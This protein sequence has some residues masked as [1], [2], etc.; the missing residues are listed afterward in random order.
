MEGKKIHCTVRRMQLCLKARETP[1]GGREGGREGGGREGGR[2][3]GGREGGREGGRVG[4]GCD[5][6]H[7]LLC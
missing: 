4:G 7:T 2:E 3:G 6:P 5:P 1:E